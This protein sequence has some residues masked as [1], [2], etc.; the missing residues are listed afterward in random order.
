MCP[1]GLVFSK[2]KNHSL[3]FHILRLRGNEEQKGR[4][5]LFADSGKS[6]GS[7]VVA[8][9]RDMENAGVLRKSREFHEPMKSEPSF[10]RFTSQHLVIVLVL[11]VLGCGG[12]G[13]VW[14][15]KTTDARAR[16]ILQERTRTAAA[17]FP[18]EDVGALVGSARDEQTPAYQR[19]RSLLAGLREAA[20]EIRF[21][22][23]MRQVD[24]KII[25]LCDSEPADSPDFSPPGSVYEDEDPEF[26]AFVEKG[27]AGTRGPQ[28]DSWGVWVTA[29]EPLRDNQGK[30]VAFLCA[31]VDAQYWAG[32]IARFQTL[33]LLFSLLVS[34]LLILLYVI[35]QRDQR[36]RQAMSRM[37]EEHAFL[38]DRIET[39]VWLLKDADTFG[40][41]NLAFA[42]FCGYPKTS[43]EHHPL[44]TVFTS[45]QE[46][47]TQ[48]EANRRVFAEKR[49][50][51]SEEW[52]MSAD[53]HTHLFQV[54]RAPL[55]DSRGEVEEVVCCAEDITE[56][57]R[58]HEALKENRRRLGSFFDNLPGLA[59]RCRNDRCWTVEFIS[60]GCQDLTG[61]PPEAFFGPDA[62]TF[63]DLV[64]P[65]E[66]TRLWESVQQ[67]NAE[68][69]HYEVRYPLVTA[70][71]A[72]KW[73]WE[74]GRGVVGEDGTI[75]TLEGLLTDITEAYL[76]EQAVRLNEMRLEALLHLNLMED[77]SRHE[78]LTYT[79]AEAVRLTQSELGYIAFVSPDERVLTLEVWSESVSADEPSDFHAMVYPVATAGA[80]GRILEKRNPQIWN[81]DILL[82]SMGTCFPPT[83]VPLKRVMNVPIFDGPKIVLVSGVGNKSTDYDESDVRQI[84]LL[85]TGMWRILQRKQA[86]Q[87]MLDYHERLQ[88]QVEART[89]QLAESNRLLREAKEAAEAANQAKSIFLATVTHELRTPLNAVLGFSQLMRDDSTLSDNQRENG[90]TINRSG[91]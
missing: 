49:P 3:S 34:A 89:R 2:R 91:E 29:T 6:P 80:W 12:I 8:N 24:E 60:K 77:R 1:D 19:L 26:R 79:L 16:A 37:A 13:S 45:D 46:L 88:E 78:I 63:L 33:P 87:E 76:A 74:R 72:R 40:P 10:P 47:Q 4:V 52:R 66:R 25:F 71:G 67:A 17:G 62:K 86:R 64:A 20:P 59:Y 9:D 65:E 55:L 7:L 27:I 54:L 61:Y 15:G 36:T 73:V 30:I 32:R 83:R 68:K 22:Y 39:Q 11:F 75:A 41:V 69:R 28:K 48:L 44:W 70:S 43:I 21:C 90:E 23:L 57:N 35:Q 56:V 14:V 5:S 85:M 50:I 82:D 38:L 84:T 42:K 18:I 51:R 81:A 53:C 31:D 58:A